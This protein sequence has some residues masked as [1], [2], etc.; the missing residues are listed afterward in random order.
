MKRLENKIII[1]TGGDGLIGKEIVSRIKA[2]GGIC[3]NA[4]INVS[5]DLSNGV[6]FC[7]ITDEKSIQEAIKKITSHYGKI[8]GLVNNA[9]PRTKDWGTKFE[10]IPL[11]SWKRNIDIQMNSVFSFCQQI[12][13]IMKAQ[14]YGSIVNI[15]SVYGTVGPDFTVYDGTEMT[16]PAAYSAIKGGIVNFSRY[17]ASYF[18]PFGIRINC[19][20]PGGIFDHQPP[21]FVSNYEKKVPMRRMGLPMDIAAPVAFLL[22]DE[23]AYITGHNLMVDGG[24]TAI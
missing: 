14:G 21:T 6:V 3:I 18:G 13:K 7:D 5:D 9:Y 17:L 8:D 24:W 22:S 16:M 19:V 1:V 12:L 23:A 15:S 20:S 10:D 4:E 2:D 11:E